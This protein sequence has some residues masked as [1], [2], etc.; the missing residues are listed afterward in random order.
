LEFLAK[1]EIEHMLKTRDEVE[2][3]L[4]QKIDYL[5]SV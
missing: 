4:R 5:H 2:A 3:D 1:R